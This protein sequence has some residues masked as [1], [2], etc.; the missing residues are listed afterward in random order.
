MA[1]LESTRREVSS[2]IRRTP[3]DVGWELPISVIMY[4]NGI[5]AVKP[6]GP[7]NQAKDPNTDQ[8]RA[9]LGVHE[10]IARYL[11]EFQNQVRHQRAKDQMAQRQLAEMQA[12][13]DQSES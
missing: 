7:M 5:I 13:F 2:I 1:S 11:I 8:D 6:R 12:E 10:T 9:W 4:D 3:G